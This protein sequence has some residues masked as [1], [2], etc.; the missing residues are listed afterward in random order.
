[1]ATKTGTKQVTNEE[2]ALAVAESRTKKEAAQRCGLSARQLYERLLD[3][4]TAALVESLRADQLRG[5]LQA[6]DDA[7]GAA[8]RCIVDIMQ[9][10]ENAPETRLKAAISLLECG[11]AARAETSTLEARA[12]QAARDAA[13]QNSFDVSFD[14]L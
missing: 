2:I 11:R 4:E 14:F 12:A 1:M 9:D 7:Q 10:A 8:I 5:R 6:L 3:R 13:R